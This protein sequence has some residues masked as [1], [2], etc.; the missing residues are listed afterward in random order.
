MANLLNLVG[1]Y[2]NWAVKE[3]MQPIIFLVYT[4][5]RVFKNAMRIQNY[6]DYYRQI[7]DNM[8]PNFYH[9][10][11]AIVGSYSILQVMTKYIP[12]VYAIDTNYLEPSIVPYYLSTKFQV[13]YNLLVSRDEYDL[14]YVAFPNWA[15]ISPKG[16]NS[17]FIIKSNLW[18]H[19]EKREELTQAAQ[20]HP[21][22]FLWAKTILGDKYRSI[23]KLTR[24]GW[25]TVLKYLQEVQ[26]FETTDEVRDVQ[27]HRLLQYVES[28]KI[29]N[30]S[31]ETN[32]YCTSVQ[33]QVNA[34]LDTDKAMIHHQLTDLEDLQALYQVNS[35]IF[36]EFPINLNFLLRS[37]PQVGSV[38]HDD[39]FWRK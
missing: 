30:T 18:A 19:V 39:Y 17:R 27:L 34:L 23:P 9:V 24:T 29:E 4:T 1:H 36:K 32:L 26:A 15:V 7:T 5:A 13:D 20:L 22:V 33:Q 10:N 28:R 2:K 37:A 25:K 16:D 14:Q 11:A 12:G 38:P 31:F 6:R 8:N 35:T 21:E 3:H